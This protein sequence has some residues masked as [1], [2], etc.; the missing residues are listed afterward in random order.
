MDGY[1]L[2]HSRRIRWSAEQTP[3]RV[4]CPLCADTLGRSIMMQW[5]RTNEFTTWKCPQ[6]GETMSVFLK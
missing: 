2:E 1:S 6:C 4:E 5:T 3:E